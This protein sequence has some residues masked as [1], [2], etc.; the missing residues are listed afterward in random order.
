MARVFEQDK[1]E[2]ICFTAENYGWQKIMHDEQSCLL[3]F[4]RDGVRMNIWYTRMTVST[5]LHHPTKGKTQLYRKN[6]SFALL[7]KLF[8]NPRTH[9]AKGYT[10]KRSSNLLRWL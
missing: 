2:Q 9:T 6:V 1:I 4:K 10:Q 7:E 8:I 5:A 3:S